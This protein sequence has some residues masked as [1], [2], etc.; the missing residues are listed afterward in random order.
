MIADNIINKSQSKSTRYANNMNK[1]YSIGFVE[2][3]FFL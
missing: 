3:I 2:I 1:K